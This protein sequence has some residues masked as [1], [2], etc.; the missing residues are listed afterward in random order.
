[1]NGKAVTTA[2]PPRF[3]QPVPVCLHIAGPP[4]SLHPHAPSS[5]TPC[6]DSHYGAGYCS[7]SDT[8]CRGRGAGPWA[9]G[10]AALP[11]P[12]PALPG[13]PSLPPTAAPTLPSAGLPRWPRGHRD[14]DGAYPHGLAA[15]L[16][17]LSPAR[18]LLQ[19]PA[20]CSRLLIPYHCSKTLQFP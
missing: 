8:G 9:A 14:P 13:A 2:K 5:K 1:M 12:C 15:C 3:P 16:Q 17:P 7:H 11:A 19:T 18:P 6:T 4:I 20:H 10:Q